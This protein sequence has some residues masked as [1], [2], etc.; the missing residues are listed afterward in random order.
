MN[1]MNL[2]TICGNSL[3]ERAVSNVLLFE[4]YRLLLLLL[5]RTNVQIKSQ[6]ESNFNL[7]IDVLYALTMN[8]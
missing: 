7:N 6:E 1:D 4:F 3:N 2:S 8:E 5:A